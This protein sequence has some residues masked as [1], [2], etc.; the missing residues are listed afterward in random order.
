MD[1][2]LTD[3]HC[4]QK[5][6][7]HKY[8]ATAEMP[9]QTQHSIMRYDRIMAARN[10]G[11]FDNLMTRNV[12]HILETIFLSLDYESYKNC[13]QVCKGWRELLGGEQFQRKADSLFPKEMY[14]EKMKNE[15]KLCIYSGDGDSEKVKILLLTGVD[16]NANNVL[17]QFP[18]LHRAIE[19]GRKDVVKLL[20]DAGAEANRVGFCERTPL[21][22]AAHFGHEEIVQLLLCAGADPNGGNITGTTPLHLAASIG[23]IDVVKLLLRSGADPNKADI[24]GKT[25]LCCSM[26]YGQFVV[27]KLLLHVMQGKSAD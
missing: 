7:L 24:N 12:P 1:D 21:H 13:H 6:T 5:H 17:T 9:E 10:P 22:F 8:T 16:P 2:S 18:P 14:E 15:L 19:M 25:P 23:R 3:F 11:G 27:A 26:K 4:L 20:L